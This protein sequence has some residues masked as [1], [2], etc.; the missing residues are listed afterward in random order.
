MFSG[1]VGN[2]LD[3]DDDNCRE[4]SKNSGRKISEP[5]NNNNNKANKAN[6]ATF[7]NESNYAAVMS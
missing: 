3:L 1:N 4:K 5:N 2:E 6:W 7:F